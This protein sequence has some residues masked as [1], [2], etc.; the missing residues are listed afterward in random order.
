MDRRLLCHI[1]HKDPDDSDPNPPESDLL[2]TP[3]FE[4][5]GNICEEVS[6][7]TYSVRK[8]EQIVQQCLRGDVSG[9]YNL[10][11]VSEGAQHH[12]YER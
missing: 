3:S 9:R 1:Q 2:P 6:G 12:L 4:I 5:L 10:G 8:K 11:L 7:A